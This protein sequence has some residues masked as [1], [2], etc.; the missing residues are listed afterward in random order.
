MEELE[1]APQL[2]AHITT[3]ATHP[4]W[5]ALHPETGHPLLDDD[6]VPVAAE[7]HEVPAHVLEAHGVTR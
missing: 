1:G 4:E 3:E 7:G 6:G 5:V 2:R